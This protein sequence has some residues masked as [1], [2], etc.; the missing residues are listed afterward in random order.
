MDLPDNIGYLEL[1]TL[2]GLTHYDGLQV[3]G[4]VNK[5]LK[6]LGIVIDLDKLKVTVTSILRVPQTISAA[7]TLN[8]TGESEF[9]MSFTEDIEGEAQ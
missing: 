6:I 4:Y 7:Y 2:A 1:A 3:G 5:E 8:V 9:S